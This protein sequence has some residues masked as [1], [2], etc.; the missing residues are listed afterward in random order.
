MKKLSVISV[1]LCLF[2]SSYGQ[3][4]VSAKYSLNS[5]PEWEEIIDGSPIPNLSFIGDGF[6]Y[7]VSYWFRL[8]NY[9]VEFLPEVSYQALKSSDMD[10]QTHAFAKN[11]Y[12]LNF[13]TQIYT[14]D[15]EG[16][17]NC[18][19]WGKDGNFIQKGFFVG[20]NPSIGYHQLDITDHDSASGN[21]SSNKISVR[22][23]V[24][25][26][27]DIGITKWITLSP[28]AVLNYTPNLG[29]DNLENVAS[30]GAAMQAIDNSKIWAIQPG[31]RLM[32]RPDYLKEQRGMFR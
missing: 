7:G 14:L 8:K 17:C 30:G 15:I 2:V 19:T 1:F 12:Y 31:I 29:W 18:P 13:N 26:G 28:F 4:S 32:F 25:A 20:L 21:Q 6:E 10:F 11:S 5:Y 3:F 23:G 24:S 27:L 9:R 16:D 22:L